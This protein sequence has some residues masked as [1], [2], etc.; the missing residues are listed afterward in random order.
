MGAFS[1]ALLKTKLSVLIQVVP[2]ELVAFD[3]VILRVENIGFENIS[4]CADWKLYFIDMFCF[5]I[6]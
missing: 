5:L 4:E 6:E 1:I 2:V 3:P